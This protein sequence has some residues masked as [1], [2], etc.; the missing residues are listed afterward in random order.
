MVV[1]EE[2]ILQADVVMADGQVNGNVAW[3]SSDDT[4]ARVNR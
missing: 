3:S 4:L 2:V 1:G